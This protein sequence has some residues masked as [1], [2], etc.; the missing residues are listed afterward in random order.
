MSYFG[1]D[2]PKEDVLVVLREVQEQ[3]GYTNEQM[4]ALV[5]ATLSYY[6]DDILEISK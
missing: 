3:R 2:S 1:H 6:T 5:V 4:V